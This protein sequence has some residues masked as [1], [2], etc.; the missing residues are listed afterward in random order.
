MHPLSRSIAAV[1]ELQ[2]DAAAIEYDGHWSTWREIAELANR[3]SSVGETEVGILLRNKPIHVAALLGV[4]LGGGT[5]VTINP[6][7]G[8]DRT[9]GDIA[10][11]DLPVVVGEPD[12]LAA[13]G[14]LA[15]R[16][17]RSRA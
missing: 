1:L 17:F 8:N 7:R 4:L 6:S 10:A 16:R 2:P 9:R 13:M 3:I 15:R 11:L 12:D 14:P 5:V